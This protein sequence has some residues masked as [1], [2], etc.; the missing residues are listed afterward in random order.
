MATWFPQPFQVLPP[1]VNNVSNWNKR[2]LA[3]IAYNLEHYIPQTWQLAD[4][5]MIVDFYLWNWEFDRKTILAGIIRQF[6]KKNFKSHQFI[7]N[8]ILFQLYYLIGKCPMLFLVTLSQ[9][10]RTVF[11]RFWKTLFFRVLEIPFTWSVWVHDIIFTVHSC[12]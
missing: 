4:I 10:E 5:H 12:F 11:T 2:T 7:C 9:E 8:I 1:L 6:I 3:L